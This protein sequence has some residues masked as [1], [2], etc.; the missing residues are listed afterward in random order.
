M[1]RPNGIFNQ[2]ALAPAQVPVDPKA[3]LFIN[4]DSTVNNEPAAKGLG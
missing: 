2:G 1:T 3:T 4:G